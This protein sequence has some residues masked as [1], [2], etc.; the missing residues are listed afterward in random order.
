MTGQ[1][2][3]LKIKK[4]N[5][6]NLSR[7]SIVTSM[8]QLNC[9]VLT[10]MQYIHCLR[11]VHNQ[12]NAICRQIICVDIEVEYFCDNIFYHNPHR[13]VFCCTQNLAW[14]WYGMEVWKIVFHSILE[15]FHSVPFWHLPY[16]IPKFRFHFI[17][18][19]ALTRVA[20]ETLKSNSRTFQDFFSSFSRTF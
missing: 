16:S 17:P 5:K 7:S 14:N 19:H 20:T 4:T 18:Y 13:Y 12:S 10:M 11:K 15:I 9:N 2:V 8:L 1:I 6:S 3:S